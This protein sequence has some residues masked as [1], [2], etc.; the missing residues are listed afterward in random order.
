MVRD[1]V[2]DSQRA[3]RGRLAPR[4]VLIA[5]LVTLG[6][7]APAHAAV[8]ETDLAAV[9]PVAQAAWPDSACRGLEHVYL[10]ADDALAVDFPGLLEANG[11]HVGAAASKPTCE[12]WVS[13]SVESRLMLCNELAHEFGH[14]A[15]TGSDA[16]HTESG[17]M[18]PTL[19]PYGPCVDRFDGSPRT[20]RAWAESLYP[21][22]T[23]CRLARVRRHARVYRCGRSQRAIVRLSA[24]G[25]VVAVERATYLARQHT[26]T[27]SSRTSTASS[28]S[29]ISTSSLIGRRNASSLRAEDFPS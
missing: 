7:S 4:S 5:V 15:L 14:L 3:V 16:D 27:C 1:T 23:H 29:T 17:I 25:A 24:A 2:R 12:V 11:A 22:G 13:S 26:T 10:N 8:T 19:Q 20:L 21:H 28:R 6:A 18:A 9:V